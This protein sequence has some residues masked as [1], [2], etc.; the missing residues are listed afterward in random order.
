MYHIVLLPFGVGLWPALLVCE[1]MGFLL[2]FVIPLV[3]LRRIGG[4][5][6]KKVKKITYKSPF[7]WYTLTCSGHTYLFGTQ[8]HIQDI[9]F[10]MDN[11]IWI[12]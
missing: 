2:F 7:V 9:P 12:E 6:S 10:H 8:N 5:N 1:I 4:F 11:F 3:F